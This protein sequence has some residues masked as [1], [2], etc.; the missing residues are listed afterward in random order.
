MQVR[1]K[2]PRQHCGIVCDDFARLRFA[3]DIENAQ[4]ALNVQERTA[5]EE[6]PGR[7]NLLHILDMFAKKG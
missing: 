1:F 4:A 3:L 2:H 5:H 6:L 7:K